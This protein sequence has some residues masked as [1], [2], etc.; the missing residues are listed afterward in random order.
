MITD[1]PEFSVE[2]E[3]GVS[4][5]TPGYAVKMLEKTDQ[6]KMFLTLYLNL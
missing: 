3:A 1:V 6:P 2:I 4:G 5:A